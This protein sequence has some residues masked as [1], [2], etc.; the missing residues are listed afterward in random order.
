M[1]ER[2]ISNFVPILVLAPHEQAEITQT[3]SSAGWRHIQRI[4]DHECTKFILDTINT[5][6][7]DTEDVI[8]KHRC[9]KVAAQLYEGGV[10]RINNEVG[11]YLGS[12]KALE[13][14]ADVTDGVLQMGPPAS[15]S[16]D[17]LESSEEGTIF[18]HFE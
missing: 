3:I 11:Q 9:A 15:T 6:S 4:F 1:I 16:D 8:E 5:P 10:Q 13:V 7:E 14:Q 2:S 12:R 18:D 17:L